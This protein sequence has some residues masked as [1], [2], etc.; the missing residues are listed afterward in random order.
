MAEGG[1]VE[2]RALAAV[3]EGP[4]KG[5]GGR[6]AGVVVGKG[7]SEE[8]HVVLGDQKTEEAA[9]AVA[10]DCGNRVVVVVVD[11]Q[12]EDVAVDTAEA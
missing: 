9:G 1:E 10:A 11:I 7:G 2:K 12:Q 4:L 3:G 6:E 8:D 5:R